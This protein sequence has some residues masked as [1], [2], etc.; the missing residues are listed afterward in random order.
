LV[1][2]V[3]DR[4]DDFVAFPAPAG[5]RGRGYMSVIGGLAIPVGAPNRAGAERLIAYLTAPA[6][7]LAM[8]KELAFF[9][10]TAGAAPADPGA[11]GP[12]AAAV[13]RQS[14]AADA[15]PT[16]LPVGLGAR[17]NDFNKVYLDTF[18]RIVLKNEPVQ[19]VLDEQARVL[20]AILNEVRA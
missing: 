3:N 4:P 6:Q 1:G 16:L 19:P 18:T 15:L 8:L 10:V 7:Q 20:Q 14:G 12:L 9:P 11:G 5:P 17:G 13:Q 2:A